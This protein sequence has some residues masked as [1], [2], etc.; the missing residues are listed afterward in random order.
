MFEDMSLERG[1]VYCYVGRPINVVS[2]TLEPGTLVQIKALDNT[3]RIP[4]HVASL[5]TVQV[6]TCWQ[7]GTRLVYAACNVNAADLHPAFRDGEAWYCEEHGYVMPDPDIMRASDSDRSW[8]RIMCVRMAKPHEPPV[9]VVFHQLSR[10]IERYLP[11]LTVRSRTDD[12]TVYEPL[13][14]F[15]RLPGRDVTFPTISGYVRESRLRVGAF[16]RW[17]EAMDDGTVVLYVGVLLCV[18]HGRCV[19]VG[20]ELNVPDAPYLRRVLRF[21]HLLNIPPTP[22]EL[23]QFCV[24]PCTPLLTRTFTQWFDETHMFAPVGEARTDLYSDDYYLCTGNTAE[25]MH[26]RVC[27]NTAIID[28]SRD[29]PCVSQ[30]VQL[31]ARG[32]P[33]VHMYAPI[34]NLLVRHVI[35]D[36][37]AGTPT[38]DADRYWAHWRPRFIHV[39]NYRDW[40]ISETVFEHIEVI[41]HGR[42]IRGTRVDLESLLDV[43]L[44]MFGPSVPPVAPVP[45]AVTESVMCVLPTTPGLRRILQE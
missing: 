45:P 32:W 16:V 31:I 41:E 23:T 4:T 6:E 11:P 44:H 35:T 15:L 38:L 17:D 30:Q 40:S 12:M 19:V 43:L 42:A 28:F 33:S 21:A 2:G 1:G 20:Q 24:S 36:A 29:W 8:T 34:G 3:R 7:R 18:D 5:D 27:A 37:A 10:A 22:A 39:G 25:Q 26:I 13:G 9:E 14:M